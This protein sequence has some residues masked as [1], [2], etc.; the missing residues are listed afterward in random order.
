MGL[1][2]KVLS[3]T[4]TEFGRRVYS[5]ASYGSDHGT[6]FPVFL[7]GK[8]LKPGICGS[9]PDLSDL[10]G[11]NLFT[12]WITGRS[13]LQLFR[14]GLVLL[15]KHLLQQNLMPGLIRKLICYGT[16]GI[17]DP[18]DNESSVLYDCIPNPASDIVRFSF[19]LNHSSNV[20]LSLYDIRGKKI[21]DI[22]N[23][24]RYY[25]KSTILHNVYLFPA[26]QYIFTLETHE[27]RQSGKFIK[28]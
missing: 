27:F 28:R 24:F 20:K 10:N 13:I 22:L 17:D 16:T 9:N 6:A 15:M 2:D 1:D 25:G 11:G 4:F 3:M 5:N 26:G 23:E 21:A 14:I 7:F 8:G 18:D 19:Y 12:K